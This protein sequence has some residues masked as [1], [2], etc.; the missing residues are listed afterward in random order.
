MQH[1]KTKR[2]YIGLTKDLEG[3]LRAHLWS[4][5]SGKHTNKLMLEDYE[6]YGEDYSFYVLE[7]ITEH[8]DRIKEYEYQEEYK[9]KD[10]LYGYNHRD[11]G[12]V[13]E[14]IRIKEGVPSIP[15]E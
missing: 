2:I 11:R 5:R 6:K 7:V 14:K 9:T 12:G 4:L 1:N 8:K 3:R 13:A 15:K 10:P